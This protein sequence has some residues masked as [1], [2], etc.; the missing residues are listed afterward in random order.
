MEIILF[1][2]E[3]LL[4]FMNKNKIFPLCLCERYFCK[5]TNHANIALSL[6][7]HNDFTPSVIQLPK[8]TG[9]AARLYL[10]KCSIW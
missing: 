4:L 8:S 9:F 1:F 3:E 6:T 2:N 5:L 7:M 10:S